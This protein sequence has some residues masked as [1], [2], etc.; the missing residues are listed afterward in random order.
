MKVKNSAQIVYFYN[1]SDPEGKVNLVL[2][3]YANFMSMVNVYECGLI[4]QIREERT[5]NKRIDRGELG[6]RIQTS[7]LGNP[8]ASEV[9]DR[10]EI[11]RAVKAGDYITALRGA[12]FFELHRAEILSL[13]NMREDYDLICCQFGAVGEDGKLFKRYLSHEFDLLTIAD[14]EGVSLDAIKQRFRRVR[15][16]IVN[17]CVHWI[18]ESEEYYVMKKGA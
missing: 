16:M 4:N 14:T 12:D 6:V 5:T 15:K 3:N 1:I 17:G 7:T 9:D 10:D 18:H 2:D 13:R 11:E 8:T